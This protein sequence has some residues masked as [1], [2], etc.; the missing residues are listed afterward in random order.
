VLLSPTPLTL[1]FLAPFLS[2]LPW[3]RGVRVLL[4]PLGIY[5]FQLIALNGM[6]TTLTG[7]KTSWKD[8]SV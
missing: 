5:L 1:L 2:L 6:L 8:R 4:A 3:Y 7:R